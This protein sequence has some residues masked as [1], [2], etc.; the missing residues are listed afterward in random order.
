MRF[1]V[2]F[3]KLLVI[4]GLWAPLQGMAQMPASSLMG[5]HGAASVATATGAEAAALPVSSFQSSLP[6]APAVAELPSWF[7]N[8]RPGP[9]VELALQTL[10]NAASQGLDPEDY[11]AAELTAAFNRAQQGSMDAGEVARLDEALNAALVRYLDHLHNGR[12]S[13]EVLK[14]RFKAPA[15][16][17]FDARGY[18]TQARQ[19]GRLA[20]ALEQAQPQT[21][22]YAAVRQFM[23]AYQGLGQHPAWGT[24][25]PALPGRSLKPGQ[26]YAGLETVAAR[27]VAL[28]DLAPTQHPGTLY[29]GEIVAAVQRFQQRHGLDPDGVI[30]PA[31]IEQLNV[32]PAQRVEQMA[33]TL[34]RLRWT[35]L[36]YGSR[37]IVVNIPEFILRA[38]EF[39]HGKLDLS[40]EMRVVVGRA[41]DTRTPIFL[42]EMRSIEFSPY[43]NVPSS[44]ARGETLPKFR[45]DPGYFERQGYEFVRR[46][47]SVSTV[48][49][50]EAIAAV[51][52]GEW[53]VRQRPGPRNA[54]GDIKFI[55]PNDQNIFLHHT[56]TPHLFSRVRRDFSH[57][58]IRIEAPVALAQFVLQDQPDWTEARI[59]EAMHSGRS[60]TVRLNQPVPVLLAYSTVV[61]KDGGKVYFLPDIYQQDARLEQALRQ[62]RSLAS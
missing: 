6:A 11:Q 39:N 42:E 47:G 7:V 57:G 26:T 43:W 10:G 13:P 17:H 59:E 53:R 51:Q 20:Q 25:L 4:G 9:E 56:S 19:G 45:R 23:N 1:S 36:Q 22:M 5:A 3:T 8:N 12:L 18:F 16:S 35:P 40:L 14:H 24:A 33:I 61:V 46:D 27:L 52:R 2:F 37:M 50:D 38:Y 60:R 31:T 58:C 29:Q 21:P 34:E 49:T 62:V 15:V 41:L 54:M 44:I 48:L 55:L 30:G 32:S 28:G